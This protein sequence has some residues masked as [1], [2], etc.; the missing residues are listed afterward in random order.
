M[1]RAGENRMP[2]LFQK[3]L[4]NTGLECEDFRGAPDLAFGVSK[5]AV[6]DT[7]SLMLV[8]HK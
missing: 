8:M 4:R 2:P 1:L 6:L 7:N 5:T 3:P